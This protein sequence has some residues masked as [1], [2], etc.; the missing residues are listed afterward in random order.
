MLFNFSE[1]IV[2]K[3]TIIEIFIFS[4]L[5]VMFYEGRVRVNG[6]KIP[7]KSVDVRKLNFGDLD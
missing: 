3:C 5:E 7:K 2:V 6:K 1:Y 4:K